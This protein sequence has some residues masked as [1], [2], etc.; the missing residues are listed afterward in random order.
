MDSPINHSA[1][2]S[3]RKEMQRDMQ[4]SL[5]HQNRQGFKT[6]FVVLIVLTHTFIRNPR[7]SLP[8][9][10]LVPTSAELTQRTMWQ[11]MSP[12]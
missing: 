2:S 4:K 5:F 8:A 11:Q 9:P 3:Y 1:I 12:W 6:I 10:W 7:R